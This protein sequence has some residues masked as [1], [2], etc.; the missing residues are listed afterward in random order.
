MRSALSSKQT[1][2][3]F[4]YRDRDVYLKIKL[5]NLFQVHCV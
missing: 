2:S 5:P 1:E 3:F 4:K